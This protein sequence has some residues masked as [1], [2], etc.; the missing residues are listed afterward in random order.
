MW[1]GKSE[2]VWGLERVEP[3]TP[4]IVCEGVFDAAMVPNAV[5]LLGKFISARQLQMIGLRASRVI[6]MLDGDAHADAIEVH[7]RFR[8]AYPRL[9][10]F[11]IVLPSDKDPADLGPEESYLLVRDYIGSQPQLKG[12]R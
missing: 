7:N 3:N 1:P 8:N 9:P 10:V 12:E 6:V 5:A 4:I 11:V 2:V